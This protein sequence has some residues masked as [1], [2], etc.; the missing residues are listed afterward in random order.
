[1]K[2]R[3]L[4][5]VA[6]VIL[7]GAAKADAQV[8]QFSYQGLATTTAG[9]PLTGKHEMMINYYNHVGSLIGTESLNEVSFRNG[10]FDLALGG[11]LPGG[12]F[13][14]TIDFS[15]GWSIGVSVDNGTEVKSLILGAPYA[16]SGG[17]GS[18]PAGD[19]V[20]SD[21]HLISK[22][23]TPPTTSVSNS[24]KITA[25]SVSNATDIAGRVSF[26]SSASLNSADY[27]TVKFNK[28]YTTAPIVMITPADG[29]TLSYMLD[30]YATSTTS[31][32]SIK[33][34]ILPPSG[35]FTFNYMVVETQ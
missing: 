14:S 15:Q 2:T 6:I 22:Q 5:L 19:I 27:V 7:L 28:P 13:P 11:N 16:L 17:G 29:G 10:V 30:F 18:A 23:T 4:W 34:G 35:T 26:T 12:G 25:C 1:M 20:I 9:I 31:D 24:V 21:G 8:R 3:Y 32:F 33:I